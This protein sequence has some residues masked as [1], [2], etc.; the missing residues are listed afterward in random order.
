MSEVPAVPAEPLNPPPPPPPPPETPRA[1]GFDF[2]KPFTYVFDDP[3]WLNKILIGGLFYLAG[4]FIIGWFF[5]FGYMARVTRNVIAGLET[6]LPEWE[7]IGDFFSEGAR[8]IAVGLCYVIPLFIVA[9]FFI[10]PAIISDAVDNDALS[11]VTGIFSGCLSCLIVPLALLVTFFLPASLL[12]AIVEQRFGAAFEFRER[13]WPFIKD[14]IGNYL[15][16]IVVYF[17]ARFI[18]GFGIILLCIGVVFTGFWSF[19][20]MAHGF[21]QSYQYRKVS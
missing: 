9:M 2:G 6:P 20:I 13:I 1:P 17:I 8:L 16:A 15:L 12:F 7:D 14:N 3:R 21:A 4:F 11:A 5:I 10:F 18:A 19:L